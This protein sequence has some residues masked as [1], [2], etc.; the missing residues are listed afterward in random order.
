MPGNSRRASRARGGAGNRPDCVVVRADIFQRVTSVLD[1]S[2]RADEVGQLIEHNMREYDE[3][4]PLLD[5]Y[6]AYR[7]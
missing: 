7:E 5:S 1:D 3:G 4:D 6:Q 2:L